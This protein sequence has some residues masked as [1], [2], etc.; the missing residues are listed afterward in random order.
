MGYAEGPWVFKGRCAAPVRPAPCACRAGGTC[1]RVSGTSE[2]E[3]SNHD[4]CGRRALFQLQLVKVE[5]VRRRSEA[6]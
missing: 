6:V 4:C 3:T 1:N 5:E 2:Q